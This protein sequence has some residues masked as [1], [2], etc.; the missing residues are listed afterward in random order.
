MLNRKGKPYAFSQFS[1]DTTTG[2]ETWVTTEHLKEQY[3]RT[4]RLKTVELMDCC[5][6]FIEYFQLQQRVFWELKNDTLHLSFTL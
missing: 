4:Y 2:F 1:F 3:P 6:A 5:V